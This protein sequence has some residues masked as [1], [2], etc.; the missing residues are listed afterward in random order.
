MDLEVRS[1]GWE[2]PVVVMDGIVVL[3]TLDDLP[4]G[5]V[6][7]L[8]FLN[9]VQVGDL[10]SNGAGSFNFLF[11]C[12]VAGQKIGKGILFTVQVHEV[13]SCTANQGLELCKNAAMFEVGAVAYGFVVGDDGKVLTMYHTIHVFVGFQNGEDC[14]VID[15][16]VL[17]GFSKDAAAECHRNIISIAFELH[18]CPSQHTLYLPAALTRVAVEVE[19]FVEV[20]GA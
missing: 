8:V 15:G 1:D 12:L 7:S 11:W 5:V 16:L 14:E 6:F 3:N 17:F 20:R 2:L 4:N 13:A 19:W 9:F 18:E 10:L